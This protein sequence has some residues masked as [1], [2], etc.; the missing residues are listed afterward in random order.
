MEKQTVFWRLGVALT[1]TLVLGSAAA[2]QDKWPQR[3]ISVV[4]PYTAGGNTD[5]ITRLI[6]E[7]VSANVGQ[8]IVIENRS[9]AG[10]VIG[11]SA[12]AKAAPDGYTFL[13]AIP[14]YAV[15]PALHKELP[16]RLSDLAPVS[17]MTRTSLVLVASNAVPAPDLN[18]MVEHGKKAQPP[19]SYGS[20]GIGSMAFLLSQRFLEATGITETTHVPYK[21]STDAIADLVGGRLGFMF[22]AVAAMGPQI[23]QKRMKAMAVTGDNRSPMLPDVPTLAELGY[24]ELVTYAWAGLLTSAGTPPAIIERMSAEVAKAARDP[25]VVQRL[26]A[27]NTEPVG[28]TPAEFGTFLDEE[29]RIGAETL[30][31]TTGTQK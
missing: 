19:L 10:G 3:A 30:A 13:V 6:M 31:R 20:S 21:G 14:G 26:A 25:A 7:R 4:V 22:D 12:V 8:P 5:V 15:Q 1:A 24:P 18:G 17:L 9:G 23:E 27:I 29:V 11:N 2:A 28:S 16:Y